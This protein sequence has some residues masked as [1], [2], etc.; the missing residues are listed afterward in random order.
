MPRENKGPCKVINCNHNANRY[1]KFTENALQKSKEKHTFDDYNYLELNDQLCDAHYLKIVE[2]DRHNK[3]KSADF[4]DKKI[5]EIFTVSE[6]IEDEWKNIT[7]NIF[8]DQVILN[9]NDFAKLINRINQLELQ[10]KSSQELN[11]K[12]I[13]ISNSTLTFENKLDLLSK[14]L[15]KE[16]RKLNH[17]IEVD[18]N[19]FSELITRSNFQLNGFFDEIFNALSPKYRNYQTRENDKKSAVGFCY[20]LA[21]ARNKFANDLKI[22]IELYL[23][24][25]GCTSSAI[26]TL[27]NLGI[28]ACYKTI[29]DYKKKIAKDHSIKISEYFRTFQ[30]NMHIFNI[31]DYHSIHS[32]QRPNSASLQNVHHMATCITKRIKNYSRVQAIRLPHG[33]GVGTLALS[34]LFSIGILEHWELGPEIGIQ[35]RPLWYYPWVPMDSPGP[36]GSLP[37]IYNGI[38]FFNPLNIEA[39]LINKYLIDKYMDY[40]DISYNTQK[41]QW[42]NQT[43]QKFQHFDRI[44]LLTIHIYDDAIVERKDERSMENIQIINIQEQK[45]KSTPDYIAAL[46]LITNIPSLYRYLDQN[47]LPVIADWPGQLYIRKAITKL[48]KEL[49]YQKNNPEYQITISPRIKNFLPILGPLYVSLN[50]REHIMIVHYEFFNKLYKSVFNIKKRNLAKNP[51]PYKINLL[52]ELANLL[53][54]KTSIFL[55]ETFY[56]IYKNIGKTKFNKNKRNFI[57]S[58][59][60][61]T[62]DIRCFP[63]GYHSSFPPTLNQY[64]ACKQIFI[65]TNESDAII[66]IC[67]HG[68]HLDCY[69]KM[70]NKCKYCIQYYKRGVFDNVKSFVERL[71]ND[72]KENT[73]DDD[74]NNDENDEDDENDEVNESFFLTEQDKINLKYQNAISNIQNW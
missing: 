27:A 5:Y 54:K 48:Q 7:I 16:Q 21:G 31:D 23:L 50:T 12:D 66:L 41:F 65:E 43:I 63:T 29:D 73:N 52:L 18:P 62:V 26:D 10:N 74:N 28:S 68:Y 38:S 6:T 36:C 70:D 51:K 64:D 1:N 72:K 35:D 8:D 60:Q 49:E 11:N 15:F 59:L 22:E 42:T 32:Y 25:S 40:F 61:Q 39:S 53:I 55:L 24:A 56:S 2:P 17:P 3:R 30:N 57:L 46:S 37:A 33:P 9:K 67:G 13:S 14:V 34:T 44:E 45:L 47:I 19:K 69:K 71:E 58:N 20:L 4:E